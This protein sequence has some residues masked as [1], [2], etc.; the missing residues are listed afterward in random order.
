[1]QI[2]LFNTDKKSNRELTIETAKLIEG[3]RLHFDFINATEEKE[4]LKIIDENSWLNDLTRRVQHYGYKYDYRARKIDKSSYLG[5]MP[6][7]LNGLSQKLV[8]EKI[9]DF[10]PDQAIINEYEPSQG[11]A[12]HID[13]EPCFGDTIISIS[14]GSHCVMNYSKEV[15]SKEK[16]ELLIEPRSLIVMTNESRYK[17]YHGIPPRKTDKFNDE[18]LKRQR[19]VSITFRKIII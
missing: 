10:I 18:I 17:W 6:K 16:E 7:W 4:L 11:I 5:D 19:R 15:N 3:L 1:M 13:C 2:D 9:I 8:N 12:S 14:L